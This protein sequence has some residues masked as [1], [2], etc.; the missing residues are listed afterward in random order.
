MGDF[1]KYIIGDNVKYYLMLNNKTQKDLAK[2]LNIS[3]SVVS[4]W[5][6]G[7]R[8][9]RMDKIDMLAKYFNVTRADII[10]NR[11]Q[12]NVKINQPNNQGETFNQ[13]NSTD[14]NTNHYTTNNYYNKSKVEENHCRTDIPITVDSKRYFFALI[15]CIRDMTD[16]K[17]LEVL[18]FANY[19]SQKNE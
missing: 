7:V 13:I 19:V 9:P 8:I 11:T 17:L 5:C 18:N 15:D 10:A 14:Q 2:E 16:D 12:T 4:S 1:L 6:T 3:K